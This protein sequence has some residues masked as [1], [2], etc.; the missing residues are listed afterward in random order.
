METNQNSKNKKFEI[1]EKLEI[2]NNICNYK[3]VNKEDNKY[4]YL[5]KI[6]LKEESKED[7]DKIKNV[8]KIISSINSDYIIKYINSFIKNN[9]FVV[10]TEYYEE[11]TLRQLINKYKKD[12]KLMNQKLVYHIIK[13]VSL[14]LKEIHN[15]NIIHGNLTPDNLYFT[16]DN[17][18]KL[19][20]FGIFSK[21]SNY[22]E[23][24]TSKNNYYNYLSPEFIKDETITNKVDIWALGCI[25]YEICTLDYCFDCNNIIGLHNKI[26]NEKNGKINLK[27]YEVEIQKLI[28]YLLNKNY[29]ER[30]CIREICNL[31]IKSCDSNTEKK[32]EKK[33]DKSKIRMLIEIKEEDIN[34]DIFF[35]DNCNYEEKNEKI[36]LDGGVDDLNESNA[37][38][39]INK[40]KYRFQKYF[41]FAETGEYNI[42]IKFYIPL[43]N[44]S[45]MFYNCKNIKILDLSSLSTKNIT[46]MSNMFYNCEKLTYINFSNFN[47]ENVT[48]MSGLFSRCSNL[49]NI[50]LSFFN[51]KNVTNISNMF[52]CCDKLDKLKLSNLNIENVTDM[53][54][55]FSFCN[56]LTELNLLNWNTKNVKNMEGMFYM[57]ENLKNLDLSSFDTS[58]VEN[59]REMF[60]HCESLENLDLLSFKTNKVINMEKMFYNC[61][62]IKDIDL[63]MFNFDKIEIISRIFCNCKNLENINLS[64]FVINNCKNLFQ[65]FL[66][67]KNIKKIILQKDIY[68][69]YI[70]KE[71]K[72]NGINPEIIYCK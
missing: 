41:R 36:Q 59:F 2:D 38:L 27:F 10:V 31:A 35:L 65:I 44:C 47:T 55:I 14:G 70:E 63:S 67:C 12:K 39:Y 50:D 54:R 11:I 3:I 37:K 23:Y 71:I 42:K 18:L 46:N 9:C 5:R 16:K 62:N 68:I 28:D 26:I 34:K 33:S 21:L 22:N 66:G 20:N 7:L 48:N 51:T 40:K 6:K 45:N 25:I 58:N 53:S 60:S 8:I 43:K 30:P 61:S 69:N 24:I 1:L 52:N 13:E 4:Y 32:Y 49:Q 15:K 19:G 57:C 29:I 17:K 72:E 64:S 56:N